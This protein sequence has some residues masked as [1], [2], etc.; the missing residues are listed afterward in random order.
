V[1]SEINLLCREVIMI[2]GG[3]IVFSDT[4]DAFNNYLKP[5]SVLVR[6]EN[7]PAE[8][9]L[10]K[11]QGV[12]RAQF[13]SDHQCRIYF[14]GSTEITERIIAASMQ[15]NWR[16]QEIQLEKSLLDDVFKQLSIQSKRSN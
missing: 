14:T 1:L 4:M 11:I 10:L 7:M 5:Q 12:N 6:M 13:I 2:E 9:A 3:R 8:T 15:H 16:V